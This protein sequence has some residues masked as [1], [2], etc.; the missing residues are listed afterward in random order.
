MQP[1][2]ALVRLLIEGSPVWWVRTASGCAAVLVH[3]RRMR[4]CQCLVLFDADTGML[5][6][7]SAH[8]F[9]GKH[10]LQDYMTMERCQ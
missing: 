2:C 6:V 8:G 7:S 9:G 3:A 1:P 4:C 5:C 10:G